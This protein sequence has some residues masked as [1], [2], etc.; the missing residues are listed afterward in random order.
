M[1][2]WI[3]KLFGGYT[4]GEWTLMKAEG[5]TK[6]NDLQDK[7]QAAE[8]HCVSLQNETILLKNKIAKVEEEAKENK[9][10]LETMSKER[11]E[12]TLVLDGGKVWIE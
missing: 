7:L 2:N 9:K 6:Q 8:E 11:Q 4:K 5:Q 1:F 10:K 12:F 3:I